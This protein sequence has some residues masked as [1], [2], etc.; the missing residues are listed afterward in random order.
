MNALESHPG[1]RSFLQMR[2]ALQPAIGSL[3]QPDPEEPMTLHD[4]IESK[5]TKAQIKEYFRLRIAQLEAEAD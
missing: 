2:A 5:P 1:L 4:L 3:P